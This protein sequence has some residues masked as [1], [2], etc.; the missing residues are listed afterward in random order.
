MNRRNFIS[1][2]GLS[3]LVAKVFPGLVKADCGIKGIG[4]KLYRIPP[5]S[6]ITMAYLNEMAKTLN[7]DYCGMCPDNREPTASEIIHRR[8]HHR[9]Q[10]I[11][12]LNQQQNL[13]TKS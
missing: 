4:Y 2:L 11:S 6:K 5:Q 12:L 7:K 9:Q 3:A 10:L 8:E 13:C 1:M